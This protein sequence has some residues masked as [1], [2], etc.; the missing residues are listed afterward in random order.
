MEDIYCQMPTQVH[1]WLLTLVGAIE[2]PRVFRSKN[3]SHDED[4]GEGKIGKGL[5]AAA[6]IGTDAKFFEREL[7]RRSVIGAAFWRELIKKAKA[8][9]LHNP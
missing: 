8:L 6:D 3:S 4:W 7:Q 5:R 2:L 9:Q 1:G